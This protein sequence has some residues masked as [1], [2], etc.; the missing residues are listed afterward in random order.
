ML[1]ASFNKDSLTIFFTIYFLIHTHCLSFRTLRFVTDTTTS[2]TCSENNMTVSL[3][4]RTFKFF[5]AS[6]LHLRY[7]SCRATQNSTHFLISTPLNGCGTLLNE[8][9]DA[10]IFWNEVLADA[11]IIDYVVTRTHDLTFPFY[12]SYSRKARL[13]HSFTP[14]RIYF[15]NEGSKRI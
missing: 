13:S 10:L 2:V 9:E 11:V 8:T 5:E 1:Y 15:G 14:Q 7:A 4:K 12:C 3:E 6:Q